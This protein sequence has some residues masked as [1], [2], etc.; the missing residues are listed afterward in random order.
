VRAAARRERRDEQSGDAARRL[1][2]LQIVDDVGMARIEA[3]RRGLVAVALLGHRQRDDP[4]L[5]RGEPLPDALAVFAGEEHLANA[6][7]DAPANSVRALLDRRVQALL[8]HEAVADAGCAQADATDAE[9]AARV[10]D[11]VVGEDRLVRAMERA[12]A[13]MHDADAEPG[14]RVGRPCDAGRQMAETV[15]VE[16][17]H[18]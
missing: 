15:E 12:D 3:A 9:R 17:G 18:R 7:D 4:R 8:R 5:A 13:E 1:R 6:A 2:L 16:P 11:R 14:R 10:R